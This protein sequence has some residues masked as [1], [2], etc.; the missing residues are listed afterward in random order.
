[1]G[2][3][4]EDG[5]GSGRTAG[6]T[7]D[8]SLRV[9]ATSL[10][11]EH[12]ANHYHGEA[13]NVLFEVTPTGADDCFFYLKNE[14]DEDMTLEGIWIHNTASEYIDVKI[15]DIGTPSG[16]SD[17]T[18]VNLNC[19]SGKSAI[20]IF[21]QGVN[22]TGLSGG[23]NTHRIWHLGSAGMAI[24]NFDQDIIVSK[25]NVVTLYAQTGTSAI[26][27]LLVFNYHHSD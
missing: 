21:Q 9:M 25:N 10:T 11:I 4:L 7:T 16:G 5:L 27:G 24:Y 2:F 8:N 12:H 15:S 19:G 17:I 14:H 18:P 23:L 3:K 26:S 6:V 13:Y 20:G 1:M 22:I